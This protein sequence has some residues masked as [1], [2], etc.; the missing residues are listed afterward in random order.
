M[1]VLG[2]YTLIEVSESLRRK[3]VLDEMYD[4]IRND[5]YTC[6]V[7]VYKKYRF[8]QDMITVHRFSRYNYHTNLGHKH[9]RTRT[10]KE[11]VALII[12][13]LREVIPPQEERIFSNRTW[14]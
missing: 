13:L 6:L 7:L 9:Y 1:G 3:G 14:L 8:R 5:E 11:T 2:P 4:V 12:Q 10:A